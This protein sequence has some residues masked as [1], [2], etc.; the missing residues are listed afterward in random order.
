MA[1]IA[2]LKAMLKM[3]SSQYQAGMK[4]SVT[5]TSK[6]QR[7]IANIGKAMGAAFTVGAVVRMTRS[8]VEFASEIRHAADNLEIGSEE[9]Q[10][11]NATA[12]RFGVT[13]ENLSKSLAKLRQTQGKVIEGDKEYLDAVKALNIGIDEFKKA[14][15]DRAL[16]M[17]AK[18]YAGAEDRALA[19]SAVTDIMGRGAKNSTAF[20]MELAEL[21]IDGVKKSASDSGSVIND[22]LLTKLE[23]LG[24]K[25]D[26]LVLRFKVGWAEAANV[27]LG[28]GTA[29]ADVGKDIQDAGLKNLLPGATSMTFFK[30]I[31]SGK[32][33]GAIATPLM[34]QAQIESNVIKANPG[35]RSKSDFLSH[36]EQLDAYKKS[37]DSHVK[38]WKEKND[39][40]TAIEKRHASSI[41]SISE[42][43]Q[44]QIQM[45]NQREVSARGVGLST[46]G[47][48]SVGGF[49]GPSRGGIGAADR[50]L[51]IEIE[52]ASRQKQIESINRR[53]ETDLSEI[54]SDLREAVG[55]VGGDKT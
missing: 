46:S 33:A 29:V 13:T 4:K 54:K 26:Q 36:N 53:M 45:I 8:V 16:E 51:Q 40:I 28:I 23:L 17:V 43:A 11:L 38:I 31:F 50:R 15:P 18:A 5:A 19:F 34:T 22:E 35:E 55:A 2:E 32:S 21:G 48:A 52:M 49:V 41:V 9:L 47:L 39:K 14:S 25:N 37:A 20:L 27:L 10:A 6:L 3:D 30:S 44:K 42:E 24:T 1:A 7:Q 12:L